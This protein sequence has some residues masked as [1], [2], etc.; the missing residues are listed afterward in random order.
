MKS[1]LFVLHKAYCVIKPITQY[2]FR[3]MPGL[4]LLISSACQSSPAA[5]AE[6]RL[7]G[8]I[9]G[10]QVDVV[11]EVSARVM[12]IAADEGER[13]NAGD[14]VVTLDDASLAMQVTQAEAAVSAAQANLAQVK[15]GTRAEAI[16][17][18]AA[19]LQQAEVGRD[20]ARVTISNTQAIRD[21]PQELTAQIDAARAGVK[22][23]AENV[24]VM[25]TR[26]AEARYWREFYDKDKDRRET[27]DKQIEI[28][29]KNLEIAQARQAGAQAQV[30]ALEAMRA[31]PL[32]IQSQVNAAQSAYGLALAKVA[33][34]QAKLAE[35][36]AGPAAEDLRLAE[37]QVQQAQAQAALARAYQSRATIAAPLTGL[38]AVRSAK[39][40]EVV[41]PGNSMLS[42]VNLD[43][44]E[45]TVY[46]PQ[47]DLPRV[48][49][50]DMVQVVVDAYPNEAFSGEITSIAQ[51]AQFAARDTQNKDDRASVVFAV[52]LRLDN[53]DGRLKAGMTA[54]A[55]F[56]LQ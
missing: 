52:K 29:Q 31:D 20:G 1:K 13:V 21:N 32:A 40:G 3:I 51:Q 12:T 9:E 55:V 39:V 30:N 35:L 25:Q 49:V 47:A 24:G 18:A 54:D 45:M 17:A 28:A 41:Q 56:S 16:D 46:V 27:L 4:L 11:A 23:A 37:A 38:V 33:V 44:V 7:T 19:T 36:Q 5:P 34:A 42:I 48:R 8:V 2:V 6:L 15:A 53:A 14:I 22:L 26:L 43:S 10:T 50:G